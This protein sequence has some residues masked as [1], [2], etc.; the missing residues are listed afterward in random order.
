MN[1]AVQQERPFD[2]RAGRRAIVLG[3]LCG[4]TAAACYLNALGNGF[5]EDDWLIIVR[6]PLV[7]A[8]GQWGELW[9]EDYWH[10]DAGLEPH[11]DLL[12][13]PVAILS[14]RL[15][16]A[17]HGLDPFGYHLTNLILHVL[18]SA[19]VYRLALRMAHSQ[20]CAVVAGCA[21]AALPIHTEA[22]AHVVGRA[23][24]LV[25]LFT[26][27]ALQLLDPSE[28]ALRPGWRRRAVVRIVAAGLCVFLA[29]GAKETGAAAVL[30]VPLF[31][32]Y[33]RRWPRR[34]GPASEGGPG[35]STC[36]CFG[37]WIAVVVPAAVYVALRYAALE[38]S[39]FRSE[40]PSVAMNL[41]VD[42][43]PLQR[44]YG[45]L[46]LWGMY[47]AKTFWPAVLVFDYSPYAVTLADRV[48]HPHVLI[49]LLAAVGCPVVAVVAYR[50]GDPAPLVWVI[51]LWISYAPV[52]NA[53]VLIK[54]T[55]AERVWYF[56]SVWVVLLVSWLLCVMVPRWISPAPGGQQAVR[57][58]VV[59]PVGVL[60]VAGWAR[61]WLRNAEWHDNGTLLVAAYRD[62]PNASNVLLCYGSFLAR[63]HRYEEGIEMLNRAL[64]VDLGNTRAHRTLAEAYLAVGEPETALKHLMTAD[65]QLPAHP[66]TLELLRQARS[67]IAARSAIALGEL[68]RQ[69]AAD[70]D[71]LD[72]LLAL[73]D[74]LM[75]AGRP[76]DAVDRL[77]QAESRFAAE[78]R[79]WHRLA[80]VAVT[81]GQQEEGAAYYRRAIERGPDNAV[82][83]VELAML[84]LDRRAEGD[85]A[86]ARSLIDC[87]ARLA[88]DHIQVR[89][90]RAEVL[91]LE[92][93]RIQA[94]RLYRAIANSLPEGSEQRQRYQ[95]R[96]D[97]LEK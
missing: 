21:F 22:V 46:Q 76:A 4:L 62:H 91:V 80:V 32:A 86:E 13:R 40:T 33:R 19:F 74:R 38:G 45:L 3:V 92:G 79:Y 65:A 52:S 35:Y 5:C 71:R 9:L 75:E 81:A 26:L 6:N 25:A 23:E 63:N 14:Y 16:H 31:A 66:R 57:R 59:V 70:P 7:T 97:F 48:T 88:P 96:A 10:C 82:L 73:A 39:L 1:G 54:T 93:R 72:P 83:L 29:F 95:L 94:A 17:I 2:R 53:L 12:Y 58:I 18:V 69:V 64:L 24:L 42:A 78:S 11:R 84:L 27:L 44:F 34:S 89:I 61:S 36:G 68:E 15:N 8:P 41:L 47:W 49:G 56:P 50:R 51:A 85:M 28:G 67:V 87:A 90:A 55:F 77:R 43:T 30:L 20:V 60:L 37:G